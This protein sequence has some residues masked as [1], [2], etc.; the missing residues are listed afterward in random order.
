MQ[1]VV[2]VKPAPEA[3]SRLR[4]TADGA[5]LD[6]EGVKFVLAGYDESA[7]EQALLLKEATPGS[8]VHVV[9]AGPP[10]RTEEV[11]RASIALGA[12][13][14]TA[15]DLDAP[16]LADPIATAR[17]LAE[18][19]AAIG[20]DLVL[21][22]KQAGDD[23]EG[24]VGGAVAGILGLPFVGFVLDL[25]AE[26]AG[27]RLTFRR[28]VERGEETW[29]AALPL[30]VGLQQAWNDPR[31]AKLPAI[32]RSR[33][34]PIAHRTPT[35]I[36]AGTPQSLPERFALPAPRQGAKMIEYRSPQEAAEKLVR[37]LREEAKVFP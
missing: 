27:G 7:L 23:E 1:I 34:A 9:A 28:S 24:V 21:F 31:T 33:K 14:A 35:A 30:V 19:I 8:T 15:V 4:A 37:L 13:A 26:P 32:L 10:G 22:G 5:A 20:H 36:A 2:G 17:A 11:L 6:V 18:A 25:R 12:D 3:E 16:P 29:E